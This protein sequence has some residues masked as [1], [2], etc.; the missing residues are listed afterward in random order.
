MTE[1]PK[2]HLDLYDD[3]SEHGHKGEYETTTSHTIEAHGSNRNDDIV[4]VIE[5]RKERFPAQTPI[6][7]SAQRFTIKASA[8][9][10][11]ITKH[12]ER[13]RQD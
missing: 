4:L 6:S 3:Y 7:K 8:L 11:L 13:Q 5:T 1:K 10:D 2:P 12:G 9:V